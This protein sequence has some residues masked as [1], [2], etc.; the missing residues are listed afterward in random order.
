MVL[1]D[2]L[3]QSTTLL[4]Q[5][6][7]STPDWCLQLYPNHKR[8]NQHAAS[9]EAL[10][11]ILKNYFQEKIPA[12]KLRIVNHQNIENRPD[13][14]AS[15]S[16]TKDGWAVGLIC[17]APHVKGVG[18]DLEF[19]D[20]VIKNGAEKLYLNNHDE[21]QNLLDLWCKKEAAFKA[22]SPLLDHKI[23]NKTF[24]LKDIVIKNNTFHLYNRDTVLGSFT[25]ESVNIKQQSFLLTAAYLEN[26]PS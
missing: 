15:L 19:Q 25:T 9:R 22:L 12:N 5:W 1:S 18:I 7:E 8:A 14:K 21:F 17:N 23:L 6:T 20:R 4:L 26:L 16:H 2:K 3:N 11:L 13:L 24:V 10:H